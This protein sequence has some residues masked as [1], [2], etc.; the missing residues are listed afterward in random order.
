M[1]ENKKWFQIKE[2]AAGQ[3]RLMFMFYVYKIFGKKA[4]NFLTF[5]VAL[6]TFLSSKSL[7]EY[8]KTNLSVIFDYCKKNNQ[9]SPAPDF[10]N[11][12]KNVFNYSLTLVDNMEIFS[13][14]YDVNKIL[15]NSENDKNIFYEDIKA[16]KGIFFICSHNGNINVLRMFFKNKDPLK[17]SDV[18]VML[19]KQQC[20]VFNSFLKKVYEKGKVK[21]HN[22]VSFFPVEEIDIDTSIELKQKLD[23]GEIAF[24]AGDR[25]SSGSANITFTSKFFGKDVEFPV[26]TFKMAQ[27]METPV[28]FIGALKTKNDS[29]TIYLEK[30]SAAQSK[31][32]SLIKME[33]EYVKFIEKLTIIDPLQFYHFYGLFSRIID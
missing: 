23:N 1:S 29:Y 4:V 33:K 14:D 3:K 13:G 15:F 22:T 7:R 24:M 8:S 9:S 18:N 17:R 21:M 30:F 28:Y 10:I 25:L 27:L 16:R 31:K 19:S 20:K 6:V 2:R 5:W 11:S 12:F 32:E 26:G